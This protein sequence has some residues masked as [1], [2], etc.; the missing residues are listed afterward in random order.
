MSQQ[1][2]LRQ[3]MPKTAEF[4]DACREAFGAEAVDRALRNAI[5]GGSDFYATENGHSIG[6]PLPAPGA[7]FTADRLYLKPKAPQP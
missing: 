3:R 5:A 2:P 7:R 4:V 6:T 1:K